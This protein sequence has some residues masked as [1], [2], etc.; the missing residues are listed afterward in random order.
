MYMHAY[1]NVYTPKGGTCMTLGVNNISTQWSSLCNSTDLYF[2][3]LTFLFV[4]PQILQNMGH[5]GSKYNDS[6]NPQSSHR[7]SRL[8]SLVFFLPSEKVQRFRPLRHVFN[9][10]RLDDEGGSGFCW[11]EKT[12]QKPPFHEFTKLMTSRLCRIHS[13]K[14]YQKSWKIVVLWL[15]YISSNSHFSITSC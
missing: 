13:C 10:L 1:I 12:E 4:V 11:P 15:E 8:S 14:K 6:K 5:F 2:E 3:W 9:T 7:N